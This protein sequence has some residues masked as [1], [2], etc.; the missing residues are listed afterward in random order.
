MS[1][2]LW[3]FGSS[4]IVAT[5]MFGGIWFACLAAAALGIPG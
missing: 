1:D 4:V 5:A 3:L 2:A